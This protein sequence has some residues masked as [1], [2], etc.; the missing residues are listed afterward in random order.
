[1]REICLQTRIQ[2][3]DR[4]IDYFTKIAMYQ[5]TFSLC[6]SSDGCGTTKV[7]KSWG[8]I[9]QNSQPIL[10]PLGKDTVVIPLSP[11]HLTDTRERKG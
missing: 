3:L 7:V 2:C 11:D 1:M 5:H 10:T 9:T 4:A 8:V 6:S